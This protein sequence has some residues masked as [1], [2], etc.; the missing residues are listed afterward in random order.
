MKTFAGYVGFKGLDSIDPSQYASQ[1]PVTVKISIEPAS[2][3]LVQIDN[4]TAA[5]KSLYSGLSLIH[6]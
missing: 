1:K 4:G 5:G 2:R 6:I 3:N